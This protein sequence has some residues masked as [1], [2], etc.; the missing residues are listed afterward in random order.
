MSLALLVGSRFVV[1]LLCVI[2]DLLLPDHDPDPSVRRFV[3]PGSE[4]LAFATK[5]DSAQFLTIARSGYKE[6][7]Q[8]AF[9]PLFPATLSKFASITGFLCEVILLDLKLR[10]N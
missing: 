3:E 5:W 7:A 9:F 6:Q 4:W 1:V 8:F 10:N 2:A